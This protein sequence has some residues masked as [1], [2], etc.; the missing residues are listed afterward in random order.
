MGVLY[1]DA[2]IFAILAW[3]FDHIIS[4]NRGRGESP[5]FPI[6]KLINLFKKKDLTTNKSHKLVIKT[7]PIGEEE[8]S[9]VRE[10]NRVY[11]NSERNIPALGLRIKCLNK[12]F[13]GTCSK[14]QVYALNELTL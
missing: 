6:K 10:K 7:K 14:E 11:E 1:A 8:E 9:A 13:R 5:F 2:A 12:T 3:Y 4:S